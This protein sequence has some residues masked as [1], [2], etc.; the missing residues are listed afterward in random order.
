MFQYYFSESE[1]IVIMFILVTLLIVHMEEHC[2]WKAHKQREITLIQ[3][4]FLMAY[5]F[6]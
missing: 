1:F 2:Q 4:T 6:L 5:I 3:N